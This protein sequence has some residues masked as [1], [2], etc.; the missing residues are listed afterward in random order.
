MEHL[1]L[2]AVMVVLVLVAI[3]L[4][5]QRPPGPPGVDTGD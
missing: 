2:I 3:A 5:N 1:K 4:F